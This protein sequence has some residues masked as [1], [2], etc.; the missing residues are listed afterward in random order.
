MHQH[1]L[2]ALQEEGPKLSQRCEMIYNALK[3]HGAMTDRQLMEHFGFNDPNTIR[4][5][6]NDLLKRKVLFECGEREDAVTGK[7]VRIV[8][9]RSK[10]EQLGLL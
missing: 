10:P 7:T 1:S 5:R 2:A 6:V 8:A 4:P 3:R 9:I